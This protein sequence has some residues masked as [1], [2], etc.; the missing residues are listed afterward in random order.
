MTLA[1]G[2]WST[3]ST[4]KKGGSYAYKCVDV[5]D[6]S[7]GYR[8]FTS[9][10]SKGRV[11][12]WVY[13]DSVEANIWFAG[14]SEGITNY[15]FR[16]IRDSGYLKL[17]SGGDT[18][19]VGMTLQ[20]TGTTELLDD[21]WYH[22][23]IDWF[24]D[25]S[26]GWVR[27]YLDG[28]L[29]LEM[30]GDTT[31]SGT[32]TDI[33]SAWF[34]NDQDQTAGAKRWD[35]AYLDD[36]IVFSHDEAEP[37]TVEQYQLDW[38]DPDGA[39]NYSNWTPT[40]GDNYENVDEAEHDSDTTTVSAT[41]AATRDSYAME[42]GAGS[43]QVEGV[44]PVFVAKRLQATEEIT[45]FIRLSS[46]DEDGSSETLSSGYARYAEQVFWTKPGGGSWTWTDIGNM[47]IGIL[48]SGTF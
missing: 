42:A 27:L 3:S 48:S 36:I 8:V 43:G 33:G 14:I 39:G 29:E 22:V 41:A 30:T 40:S 45:P 31:L 24:I 13:L 46:T 21:T 47:E 15:T 6:R 9:A 4:R 11:Q 20:D 7:Y 18:Y 38:V 23:A 17:Y 19:G 1:G 12:F 34:S 37:A 25:G 2:T 44:V 28:L 32:L 26:D 16:T 5:L 10:I 35:T